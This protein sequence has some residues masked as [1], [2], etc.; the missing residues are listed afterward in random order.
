MLKG[1]SNNSQ[2]VTPVQAGV[3]LCRE[4]MDSCFRRSDIFRGG[5]KLH[6]TIL[7]QFNVPKGFS[8]QVEQMGSLC[9]SPST[10][11]R[12]SYWPGLRFSDIFQIPFLSPFKGCEERSHWLKSPAK[13]TLCAEGA[14]KLNSVGFNFSLTFVFFLDVVPMLHLLFRPTGPLKLTSR[15]THKI[16]G[17]TVLQGFPHS[18]LTK[19]LCL[20]LKAI[21]IF[22]LYFIFFNIQKKA[23]LLAFHVF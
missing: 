11:N 20:F 10:K 6:S 3:Q 9:H 8:T 23:I 19:V 4:V 21:K 15:G 12:Y 7:K 17:I 5:L 14:N 16:K 22:Q 1:T 2:F 18:I 13:N